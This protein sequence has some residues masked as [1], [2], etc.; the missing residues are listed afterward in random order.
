MRGR[1]LTMLPIMSF[2][3]KVDCYLTMIRYTATTAT[4]TT[5]SSDNDNNNNEIITTKKTLRVQDKD[6]HAPLFAETQIFLRIKYPLSYFRRHYSAKTLV[7]LLV[8]KYRHFPLL[9]EYFQNF[10][11]LQFSEQSDVSLNY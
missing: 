8:R 1:P 7:H 4:A 10:F 9:S 3:E 6:Y 11:L 2:F 5:T